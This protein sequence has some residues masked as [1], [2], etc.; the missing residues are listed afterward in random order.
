MENT[1]DEKNNIEL[2]SDEEKKK[3]EEEKEKI[4]KDIAKSLK[5]PKSKW[6]QLSVKKIVELAKE[7]IKELE[8]KEKPYHSLPTGP[9]ANSIKRALEYSKTGRET[10][11]NKDLKV[12]TTT[13]LIGKTEINF[14]SR[15]TDIIISLENY[16]EIATRQDKNTIKLFNFL[17]QKS[18]EQNHN[19]D[20]T[21]HLLELV[22]NGMYKNI[23]TARKGLKNSFEKIKRIEIGGIIKKGGKEL[24]S[25]QGYLFYDRDITEGH[26]T[27]KRNETIS[28]EFIAQ[29]ITLI[30]KWSYQL[31]EKAYSLV[32]YIFYRARQEI[33]NIKE[34]GYFNLS[35][36]SISNYLGQ[37]KPEE[38]ERQS[39]LIIN[40]ILEAITEIEDLQL[41]EERTDFKI[42]PIY[43]EGTAR[44]FLR[45]YL[46]IELID[47]SQTYFIEQ[48]VKKENE[49]KKAIQK[50]EKKKPKN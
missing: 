17:L 9:V 29:Y 35:F 43:E 26:V 4:L 36:E 27:I 5:I 48:A 31:N 10:R 12:T 47:T 40:P 33:T 18:N 13:N 14:K 23:D 38:T 39:Q 45:G 24:R 11:G 16:E 3:Y 41:K 46:K 20:I 7:Q 37:P 30:P 25:K 1:I 6:G 42:T 32:D 22:E 8:K 34:K 50:S 21:F 15:N 49:I 28:I 2:K 19:P 44:E